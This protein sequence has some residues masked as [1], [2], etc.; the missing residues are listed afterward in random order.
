MIIDGH[1]HACGR[2][3][4]P[5]D[6]IITL[7]KSGADKVILV[8][9][10]SNSKAEYSLP[11]L[12]ALFPRL[13]V[14][15]VTNFL[16]KIFIKL[17]GMIDQIPAGNEYVY[18]L[19][20]KTNGQVI[21]FIWVTTHI[22]NPIEYLDKKLYEWQFSGVKLHQVW[23]NFSIGSEFF[24]EIALWAEKNDLP[25]FIHQNSDQEV[26]KIIDYKCKHPN[27]KL[28]IAHLF[29]LELFIK[30]NCIHQN[31]FFDL[32]SPQLVSTKRIYMA[33]RFIGAQNLIL[34]SDNPYGKNNLQLNI[35]RI[36]R[37]D[38]ADQ[39]KQS[40]LGDNLLLILKKKSRVG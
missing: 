12:A 10:E 39:D 33:L 2:Y 9:G 17:S 26:E 14:V 4:T 35:E 24:Y 38:I 23:D 5:D 37:L 34:G 20:Q 1:A 16:T 18:T 3:L 30:K 32:S 21:Q 40:I 28:I 25:L 7:K 36:S 13:N 19:K 8:P 15:K 6:I 31:L 22:Q 11:N 27:L 29:G